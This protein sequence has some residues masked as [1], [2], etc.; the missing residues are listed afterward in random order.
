M[1]NKKIFF[2]ILILIIAALILTGIGCKKK[3]PETEVQKVELNWWGLWDSQDVFEDQIS[4]YRKA[5]P[6][7]KIKYRKL[8]YPEYEKEVVDALAAGKG[9]DIWT[10][11]NT[12]LPKHLDK[13]SPM[14]DAVMTPDVYKETFV[15]V[16][17]F[18]FTNV[19]DEKI[20]AIPFS[21]D[22]LALY[23]NKDFLGTAG[24][25]E[26]PTNWTE[27]KE[28]VK[29]LTRVDSFGN[30][31]QA[32]AALGTSK[33]INRAVDILYL[34]ML[35]NGTLMTDEKNKKATFETKARTAEGETYV[36]GIDALIFYTDFAS[37][38]KTVYTWNPTMSYSIDAFVE[39]KTA[40]MFNYAYQDATIK[41][42]APK[43]NYA[44]A[45]VP[46]I[47]GT[48]KEVNFAN[49]WAQVVSKTSAN[50]E[51]AWDFLAYLARKE[52]VKNYVD[53][54]KRPASRRD[55]IEDQL[56]DPVLKVFAKQ[57]LTA[58]SWYQG[59]SAAIEGIFTNIIESVALG[60]KDPEDALKTASEQV[61]A[62]M[63]K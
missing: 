53:Q 55:V 59:D 1:K 33:N 36:P 51:T 19:E 27:F 29:K 11:H 24:I 23:Y 52:N 16:A 54:T 46:Q 56:A 22:T 7:I 18:D 28:D 15:D 6:N 40:M 26:P 13:L 34:L 37:P 10:I 8:T 43:L 49:Y 9:P 62:T 42:K 4:A 41:S 45:P 12:W 21:V 39:E 58:K 32:G 60:E 48:I 57:A 30:I 47:E 44:V 2:A 17:S 38:K 20:Y 35:Q 5:N 50:Q 14:P 63:K 31:T 61:T 25:A 3:A